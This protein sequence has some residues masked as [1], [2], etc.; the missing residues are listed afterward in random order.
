MFVEDRL[1]QFVSDYLKV[2]ESQPAAM[3]GK[4]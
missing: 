1:L 2:R 3:A 4:K